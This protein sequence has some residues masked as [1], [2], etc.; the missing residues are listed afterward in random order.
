LDRPWSGAD[1]LQALSYS[2][3]L[4]AG[5]E[6]VPVPPPLLIYVFLFDLN[7]GEANL[8]FI[9][10]VCETLKSLIESSAFPL[11]DCR[12]AVLSYSTMIHF[13]CLKNTLHQPKLI[14]I[15]NDFNELP[16][17]LE[18]LVCDFEEAKS[19]LILLLESLPKLIDTS[20]Q[21]TIPCLELALKRLVQIFKGGGGKILLFRGSHHIEKSQDKV[22]PKMNKLLGITNIAYRAIG[23]ELA[24]M[25]V[26]T[27]DLFIAS[28]NYE[29]L[30]PTHIECERYWAVGVFNEWV[31]L[32]LPILLKG[33]R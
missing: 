7:P 22:L 12:V 25:K 10:A 20:K 9:T 26:V 15:P 11:S 3:E 30:L 27:C 31:I 21:P 16:L 17:P 24:G 2:Y 33:D 13:Y 28:N 32:L 8:Q 19:N 6:F 23:F 5:Q 4:P 1:T 18:E 14:F 29:V